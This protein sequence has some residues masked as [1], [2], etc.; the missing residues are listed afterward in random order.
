M[1]SSKLIL[2]AAAAASAIVGIGAASA[3]DL[4]MYAKAAPGVVPVYNWTGFYIGGNI[5]GEW[6]RFNDPFAAGT[7]TAFG[8]TAPAETIPLRSDTSSFTAGGQ[9]GYRWQTSTRWV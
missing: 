4:P 8:L 5:G 3:A 6:G 2:S 7:V 9:I 1:N